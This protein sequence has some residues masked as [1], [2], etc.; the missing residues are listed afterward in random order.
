MT[1]STSGA[2][3]LVA[4]GRSHLRDLPWRRTREPWAILIC[5]VMSQQ[6]TITRV[7]ERWPELCGWY[8]LD[9]RLTDVRL[10]GM[11]GAGTEVFVRDGRLAARFLTPIPVLYR[12]FPLTPADASDPDVLRID[13]SA[14]GGGAIRLVFGRGAGGE[15]TVAH[16]DMMPVTLAK[17]S[18][19]SNPRRW[20]QG[21]LAGLGVAAAGLV[22]RRVLGAR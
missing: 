5:E 17:G 15:V 13:L 14:V 2:E 8:R 12:G 18:E 11:L 10:R 9:A 3:A 7:A 6:T 1:A 19:R 22:L 16:L 4:W 21:G 20:A